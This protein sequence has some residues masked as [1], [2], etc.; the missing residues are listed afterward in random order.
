MIL[1]RILEAKRAEIRER[2]AS[3]PAG[4][5]E[6]AAGEAPPP[7]DFVGALRRVGG[8][9]IRLIAEFKRASPSAGVIRDDIG[10]AEV[11]RRYETA[12]A[13]AVSVLTDGR[14][15]S[16]SLA[17]LRAIR[18]TVDMPVLRKDFMLDPYQLLE[19][20]AAGADAVLLIAA[21]LSDEV[22]ADLHNR[23]AELGLAALVEAH[24]EGELRR[25][26]AVRPRIVGINN[27]DL[28]KLRVD[29][30]TVIRLR[31]L[32]PEGIV[33]VGESGVH[34]RSDMLRLEA[35]GIDAALVGEALMRREDPGAALRELIGNC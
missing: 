4:D 13:A 6:R 26:L 22:L 18:K 1:E 17:D 2:K 30:E 21:A 35:A 3:L 19:A 33:V 34:S 9:P 20:R 25:A 14:F 8:D 28:K 11:A 23:A 7:R 12:G 16:G 31:P 10:P 29:F 27:R 5:L 32:I 24:T 15:F